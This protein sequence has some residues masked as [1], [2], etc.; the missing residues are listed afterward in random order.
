[1]QKVAKE[2]TGANMVTA[3][4]FPVKCWQL[5]LTVACRRLE[6]FKTLGLTCH[7]LHN[8][9]N[10][11]TIIKTG[12]CP[13][14]IKHVF[15]DHI[16]FAKI[17]TFLS[18]HIEPEQSSDLTLN[19]FLL[20]HEIT[21]DQLV[22]IFQSFPKLSCLNLCIRPS[23]R[24]PNYIWLRLCEAAKRIHFPEKLEL[25]LWN[26]EVFDKED[27]TIRKALQLKYPE[28]TFSFKDWIPGTLY[29]VEQQTNPVN[30]TY[31]VPEIYQAMADFDFDTAL[32]KA[33]QQF[34]NFQWPASNL[35]WPGKKN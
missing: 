3:S 30:E 24:F 21:S 29:E 8:L 17:L 2:A 15:G 26:Q 9:V 10:D 5:I 27:T 35:P 11:F 25:V 31:K 13:D 28:L 34:P 19:L 33:Q 6:Y 23:S 18:N 12:L 1:M 22:D 4:D 20:P 7:S 16:P 14:P 32:E